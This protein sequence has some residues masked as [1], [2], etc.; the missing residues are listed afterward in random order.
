MN[1]IDPT[2]ISRKRHL[3]ATAKLIRDK[4][5]VHACHGAYGSV[6]M[7]VVVL[8]AGADI[9][10][11]KDR[12]ASVASHSCVLDKLKNLDWQPKHGNHSALKG[13]VIGDLRL[14]DHNRLVREACRH[15][16]DW[17]SAIRKMPRPHIRVRFPRLLVEKVAVAHRGG[18]RSAKGALRCALGRN[19]K[20]CGA[21]ADS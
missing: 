9:E 2:G 17:N 15:A 11:S 10:C 20:P 13:E 7:H 16:P 1:V 18:T 19:C 14:N 3:H 21:L 8:P 5:E 6:S 4:I 12:L